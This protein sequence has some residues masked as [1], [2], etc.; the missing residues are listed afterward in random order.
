MTVYS[1]EG[2]AGIEDVLWPRKNMSVPETTADAMG[3]SI[4]YYYL[5]LLYMYYLEYI[6][7]IIHL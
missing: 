5:I 2:S 7:K 6:Y 3:Y 1:G 4:S